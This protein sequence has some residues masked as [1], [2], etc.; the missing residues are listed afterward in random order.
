MRNELFDVVASRREI[1]T[2]V[3]V[4]RMLNEMFADTGSHRKAKVGVDVDFA[5]SG[6]RGF[7]ELIFGNAD[8]VFQ[9]A[10]VV[11]DDFDV[12]GNDRGRA[13]KDNREAG[14]FLFDFFE[15][16]KAQFGRFKNAGFGIARAL[17][18][19][20]FE[21]AVAGADSDCQRV[22]TG[23]FDELEIWCSALCPRQRKLRLRRPRADRVRLRQQRRVHVRIQRLL[24]SFRCFRQTDNASRRT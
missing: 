9:V 23:L 17:F 4:I 7:A 2:R 10:A 13:V 21:C 3:E 12:F 22:A 5:D 20:E 14:D 6:F 11:V 18:G 1:L 19:R 16:V 15:N 24:W 8:S